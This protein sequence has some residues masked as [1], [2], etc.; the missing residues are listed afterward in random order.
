MSVI[1]SP[2]TKKANIVVT[3]GMRYRNT[4]KRTVPTMRHALAH[5]EKQKVDAANPKKIKL[6]QLSNLEKRAAFTALSNVTDK[7]SV[8]FT[9]GTK[10]PSNTSGNIKITAHKNARLVAAIDEKPN[11][12]I[13]ETAKE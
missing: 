6:P 13:L 4:V 12:F 7:E 9:D 11:L 5:A 8:A 10:A 3:T 2:S 1:F